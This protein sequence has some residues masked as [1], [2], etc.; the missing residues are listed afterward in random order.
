ML[1]ILTNVGTVTAG[2]FA[3]V[4]NPNNLNSCMVP[5]LYTANYWHFS[6]KINLFSTNILLLYPWKYQKIIDFFIFSG[7]IDVEHWLKWVKTDITWNCYQITKTLLQINSFLV[8][9][10]VS[11]PLKTVENQCS[12]SLPLKTSENRMVFWCF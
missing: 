3:S 5:C 4:E 6:S 1:Q 7:G 2:F 10:P 12:L 9:V 11:H 8:N